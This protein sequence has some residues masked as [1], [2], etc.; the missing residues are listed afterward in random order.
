MNKETL[1]KTLRWL[2][3]DENKEAL[4]LTVCQIK[5]LLHHIRP[6]KLRGD[7]TFGLDDP[8]TVGRI[9]GLLSIF[10]PVYEKECTVTP[11][12]DRNVLEGELAFR[13]HI[14]LIHVAVVG[15]RLFRNKTTRKYILK[16][17]KGDSDG[18]QE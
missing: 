4:Q 5:Y 6:R 9:L 7:V 15:I 17:I 18:G 10:Y 14:R 1:V 11:V 13:G 3:E 12:F 16:A 8:Y 2:S